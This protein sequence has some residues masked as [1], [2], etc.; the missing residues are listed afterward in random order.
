M[1]LVGLLIAVIVV[2]LLVYL[3][4]MLPI[5][6]PFKNIAIIVLVIILIIWLLGGL[7][8]FQGIHIR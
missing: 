8:G 3:I 4:R 2:G 6:E 7:T 1:S 5:D